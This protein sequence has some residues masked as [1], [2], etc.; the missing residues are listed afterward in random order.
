ME[1]YL[2]ALSSSLRVIDLRGYS[3]N[4]F[5]FNFFF[6]KCFVTGLYFLV[7]HGMM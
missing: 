2:V 6:F 5:S 7:V 1:A 4:F 3:Y